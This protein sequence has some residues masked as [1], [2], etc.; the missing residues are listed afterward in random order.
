MLDTL[1][2]MSGTTH[3]TYTDQKTVTRDL[4]RIWMKNEGK[5]SYQMST[6]EEPV[7]KYNDMAFISER[8]SMIFR[9]GD[10]PIWNR[11]E[12]I[13]PMSWRLFK[14]T[15]A[16]PGKDYTLQTI[17]TLSSAVDFDVRKNQPDFYKMLMKRM[18]QAVEA[19]DCMDLY[20]QVY[21]Y[22][23]Y[24]ISR[25]NPDDYS[26]DI[27]QLINNR[28]HGEDSFDPSTMSDEEIAE[29]ERM[30]EEE[31]MR[32]FKSDITSDQD[33]LN[34]LATRKQREDERNEKVYAN[35]MLSKADL[36][37][38]MAVNHG[39]DQVFVNAFLDIKQDMFKSGDFTSDGN[40]SLLGRNGEMYIRKNSETEALRQ[41]QEAGRDS[42]NSHVYDENQKLT[43]EQM[44]RMGSYTVQDA[45]LRYL[46]SLPNWKSIAG[47]KFDQAVYKQIDKGN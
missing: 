39:F 43:A 27:M 24:D 36:G 31:E 21:G 34:E 17:P 3:R 22:T 10:S 40:G 42:E 20:Q 47:G 4:E 19:K 9:A 11:N 23:D 26:M 16:V 37:T 6:K 44:D 45:F 18:D 7:I 29:Q 2:K 33:V 15:I 46:M 12:T 5:A 25:L 28:L 8:N 14:N 13:L 1:Q 35:G 30:Q 38:E 41:L 32:S